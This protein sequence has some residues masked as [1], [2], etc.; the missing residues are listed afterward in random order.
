AVGQFRFADIEVNRAGLCVNRDPISIMN[1]R[2]WAASHRFGSDM[3]DHQS[4]GRSA[5]TS[6]GNHRAVVSVTLPNERRGGRKHL[7]HSR[8]AARSLI[9]DHHDIAFFNYGRLDRVKRIFLAV[10]N[11]RWPAVLEFFHPGN[12]DH[13]AVWREVSP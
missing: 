9:A 8:P 2:D 7:A 1:Q 11:P 4:A 3:A 12:L 6:I 10:E 5:E 13:A